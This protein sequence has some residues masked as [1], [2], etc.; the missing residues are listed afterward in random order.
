MPREQLEHGPGARF[1]KNF[2][3][4]PIAWTGDW[5]K[6]EP[7]EPTWTNWMRFRQAPRLEDAFLQAAQQLV[8]LDLGMWFATSMAYRPEV[9][10]L[11]GPSLDLRVTFHRHEP[12]PEEWLLADGYSPLAVDGQIASEGRVWDARGRLLASGQQQ[13]LCRAM[14][15][16]PGS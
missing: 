14:P 5:M 16:M 12:A 10:M 11:I 3:E 13:L 1:F 8:L 9:V 6:R 4:R 2:E 15:V 7:G